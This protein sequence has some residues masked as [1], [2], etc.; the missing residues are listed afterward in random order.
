MHISD[1]ILELYALNSK[2]LDKKDRI[3]IHVHLN[4]CPECKQLM[5]YFADMWSGN[6]HLHA[7]N[8]RHFQYDFDIGP[9]VLAAATPTTKESKLKHLTNCLSRDNNWSVQF[10][11]DETDDSILIYLV[12]DS[13][14]DSGPLVLRVSGINHNIIIDNNK[15]IKVPKSSF[16]NLENWNELDV[17]ILKPAGT[18]AF[19]DIHMIEQSGAKLMINTNRNRAS[20]A[21]HKTPRNQQQWL[22]VESPGVFSIDVSDWSPDSIV[23]YYE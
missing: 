14:E 21:L 1:H 9:M 10:F 12:S 5:N 20:L 7:G 17:W 4:S 11:S 3:S 23:W 6:I 22:K 8:M 18:I 16:E 2:S 15:S 13:S 19:E